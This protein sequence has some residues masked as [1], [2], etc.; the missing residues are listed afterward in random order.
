MHCL[1]ALGIVKKEPKRFWLFP[2]AFLNTIM[3]YKDK[4]CSFFTNPYK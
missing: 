1:N 4:A 3:F 2:L